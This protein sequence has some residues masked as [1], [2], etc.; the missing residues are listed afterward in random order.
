MLKRAIARQTAGVVG[1]DSVGV[2]AFTRAAAL[3]TARRI[4]KDDEPPVV[5]KFADG[6]R[7]GR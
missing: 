1:G 5:S 6:T 7:R 4:L 2:V 3:A